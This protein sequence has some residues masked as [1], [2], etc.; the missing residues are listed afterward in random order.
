M[1]KARSLMS[2]RMPSHCAAVSFTGSSFRALMMSIR[3]GMVL[4]RYMTPL[5]VRGPQRMGRP[6]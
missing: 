6:E 5:R 4:V 3:D 1:K 2:A